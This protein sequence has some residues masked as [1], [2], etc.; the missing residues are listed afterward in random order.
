MFTENTLAFSVATAYFYKKEKTDNIHKAAVD[1][2][3]REYFGKLDWLEG[4][5]ISPMA[6]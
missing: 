6:K 5:K 2:K 1:L 3:Y 4:D